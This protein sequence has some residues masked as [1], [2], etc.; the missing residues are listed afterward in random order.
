MILRADNV[1]LVSTGADDPELAQII[2]HPEILKNLSEVRLHPEKMPDSFHFRIEAEDKLIGEVLLKSIK[3][4]NRKAE[5]SIALNMEYQ[6]K[7]FG[8]NALHTLIDYAF[9]SVN[10]HRLEA[11]IFAYNQK[12]KKLFESIGFKHEGTLREARYAEGKYHDILRYGILIREFVNPL[13]P[14]QEG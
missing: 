3:W 10:L 1:T 2:Q 13:V 6:G 11:E 14:Q 9:N 5:V 7:G 8:K 12:A 4:Y